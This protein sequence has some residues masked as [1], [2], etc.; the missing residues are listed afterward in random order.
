MNSRQQTTCVVTSCHFDRIFPLNA[1]A[2]IAEICSDSLVEMLAKTVKHLSLLR[3]SGHHVPILT[4]VCFFFT[5]SV[6]GNLKISDFDLVWY[7]LG[8]PF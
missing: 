7:F 3:D 5:F 6:L 1:A 4:T 8:H 2:R